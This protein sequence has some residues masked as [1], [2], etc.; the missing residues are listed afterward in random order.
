MNLPETIQTAHVRVELKPRFLPRGS[1]VCCCS[2]TPTV[3]PLPPEQLS[4]HL[5]GRPW[6]WSTLP[7]YGL[8]PW[9][10]IW[11]LRRFQQQQQPTQQPSLG[12]AEHIWPLCGASQG[13]LEAGCEG[14]PHR[15]Q[16]MFGRLGPWM[17]TVPE[18]IA[19]GIK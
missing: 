16:L 14:K 17:G 1:G 13:G 7:D 3:S 15:R 9:K 6:T 4:D 11:G 2:K 8:H 10:S 18:W 19:L 12:Q 5:P